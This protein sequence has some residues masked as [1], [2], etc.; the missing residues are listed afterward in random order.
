MLDEA[1]SRNLLIACDVMEKFI[2]LC[3]VCYNYTIITLG[4]CLL[5]VELLRETRKTP[6]TVQGGQSTVDRLYWSLGDADGIGR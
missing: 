6:P 2:L 1:T 4:D 5:E 3:I